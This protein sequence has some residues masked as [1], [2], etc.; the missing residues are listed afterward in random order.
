[1]DAADKLR[2]RKSRRKTLRAVAESLE[3]LEGPYLSS[4]DLKN[5]RIRQSSMSL[6]EK[7]TPAFFKPYNA[8]IQAPEIDTLTHYYPELDESPFLNAEALGWYLNQY[9]QNCILSEKELNPPGSS[10]VEFV[11]PFICPRI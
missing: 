11:S 10:Y 5:L 4:A 6:E 9:F 1:M 7:Q 2:E 3:R 8:P